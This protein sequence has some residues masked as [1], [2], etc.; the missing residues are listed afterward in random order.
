MLEK[1]VFTG[2]LNFDDE[3]RL[4]PNGDYRY[5]LNMR[6]SLADGD[7]QGSGENVKGDTLY[8]YNLY[9]DQS[10]CI[11]AYNDPN[12]K[13]VYYV[14]VETTGISLILEYDLITNNIVPIGY[15]SVFNFQADKLILSMFAIGGELYINDNFNPP[16]SID[17]EKGR[18][19]PTTFTK[20]DI[21]VAA[22]PPTK[23][24]LT[25]FD[26][27][28]NIGDAR[29]TNAVRNRLYQFTYKFVYK[30][31]KESAW[32]PYSKIAL[33]VNEAE[34]RPYGFYPTETNNV[35]IVNVD[36]GDDSVKTIKIAAR[37]G[38]THDF[39]Q[40]AELEKDKLGTTGAYNYPFY[41]DEVYTA[42]DNTGDAGMR[43]FDNIP[44]KA[45]DQS[46]IDGNRLAYAGVTDGFDPVDI[47]MDVEVIHNQSVQTEAPR[48]L[49]LLASDSSALDANLNWN[50]NGFYEWKNEPLLFDG[51]G[52]PY[53]LRLRSFTNTTNGSNNYWEV[54]VTHRKW[55]DIQGN[56][57]SG[58]R[59]RQQHVKPGG[60]LYT[61]NGSDVTTRW[62][63]QYESSSHSSS[64]LM[65]NELYIETPTAPGT[66]Y[67]AT[68][69]LKYYDM[70]MTGNLRSKLAKVQVVSVD[71]DTALT[72]ANKLSNKIKQSVDMIRDNNTFLNLSETKVSN[73]SHVNGNNYGTTGA[74]VHV[75]GEGFVPAH[76]DFQNSNNN[77]FSDWHHENP[78]GSPIP[79]ATP[80]LRSMTSSIR[81][82]ADWT[83][84][85]KRS[86]KKGATHGVGLVYYDA[87]NKSGLTN[88]QDKSFYVPFFTEATNNGFIP[89]GS[90]P[91]DTNL[92]LTVKHLPPSWATHYQVVYTGNKTIE[93]IPSVDASGYSGF[94]QTRIKDYKTIGSGKSTLELDYLFSYNSTIPE[95]SE[96]TY[97]FSKGDRIRFITEEL[98]TDKTYDYLAE[99]H[100]VEI[101]SY[102]DTNDILTFKT[103]NFLPKSGSLVE[104][105]TP[106]KKNQEDI[107]YEV[108][109]VF[110]IVGGYHQGSEGQNQD[111]STNAILDIEDM[112][113]VYL[114]Y[115]VDPIA[116]LVEDYSY[117]DYY[118]SDSWD[119]GRGNIV[120]NNIKETFRNTTIRYSEPFIPETNINGL[121][122]FN[123][124]SFSAYDHKYGTIKL[125]HSEDKNL[126][127]FQQLKT[128]AVGVNQTTLYDN[129]G[130]PVGNVGSATKVLSDMRYYAGEW[131]IGDHPE[132][133]SVYGKSKYFADVKRGAILRLAGDGLNPISKYKAHNYFTDIFQKLDKSGNPFKLIGEYDV[134][135]G[136][137]ILS[138]QGQSG[139]EMINETIAFSEPKNRWV[140]FYS[141]I[142]DMMVEANGGLIMFKNGLLYQTNSS[143]VY[144][145]FFGEQ[146]NSKIQLV[147]NQHPSNIKFYNA[148][149]VEATGKFF[150][151][152]ATN[153][154]GQKT[155][156]I[157]DDFEDV[158]SVYKA[159]FLQDVN[160]PNVD[161]PL[162][163]GDNIRGNSLLITLENDSTD[164]VKIFSVGV[165][166]GSS[167]LSNR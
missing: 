129:S 56:I 22:Y 13:K 94:I 35:I 131:G 119:R 60:G 86:L 42:I 133:F 88:I 78:D 161:I 11:G 150:M 90:V 41:N 46:L 1:K 53:T 156:L 27:S 36:L 159:A 138:I 12:S 19:A 157:L 5:A 163:E 37:E 81:V 104:L 28:A 102:D 148:L 67:V 65:L 142:P 69:D 135:F 48:V 141:A 107:Y 108:G 137:Y 9:D 64:G 154:N 91:N 160:T 143:D 116:F 162:I 80:A 132:S 97:S 52:N 47:D 26:N 23:P 123:D 70:G 106:K 127:V 109:E 126:I 122:E 115:R 167:E 32:S 3:D 17:I 75:W 72:V 99:Y 73:S 151:P 51:S 71:G 54:E 152:E 85:N 139:D 165:N 146:Y 58:N 49:P 93:K 136:E 158:E 62:I 140:T 21:S 89:T 147:S 55:S 82:Y 20:Q 16:M 113:D 121:S 92:K 31:N 43:L 33:P 40:V 112:G 145:N 153:H 101:L 87:A 63:R 68:V 7:S 111:A 125:I 50:Y 14:V 45:E 18:V 30:N 134:R 25:N 118:E 84:N 76:E 77:N 34:F 95:N 124:Y 105:Y 144:N 149:M 103:P 83:T 100:E 8:E 39:F 128:G 98:K 74:V 61:L 29:K 24:P 130:N 10:K 96:L 110:D 15:S 166:F 38:N 117:S 120:D 66:R 164:F 155:S 57:L 2:G 4:V 59:T 44:K 6:L 79:R 114:R